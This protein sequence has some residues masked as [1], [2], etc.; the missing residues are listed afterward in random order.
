MKKKD[1]LLGC[2]IIEILIIKKFWSKIFLEHLRNN[3]GDVDIRDC[4]AFLAATFFWN[5]SWYMRI[6]ALSYLKI[7]KWSELGGWPP[8]STYFSHTDSGITN[9][10][11][12]GP[13]KHSYITFFYNPAPLEFIFMRRDCC[14]RSP[15]VTKLLQVVLHHVDI[16]Q[17]DQKKKSAIGIH[18]CG[19]SRRRV[20]EMSVHYF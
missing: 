19:L 10:N 6:W 2:T 8:I 9:M 3:K 4:E 14:I 18:T 16:T 11:E 7:C 12:I 1:L 13:I 17:L 20:S 5:F 15:F